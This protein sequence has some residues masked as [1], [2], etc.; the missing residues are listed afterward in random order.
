MSVTWN[1]P[2][3]YDQVMAA[4]DRELA[5]IGGFL[6]D[7]MQMY[8]PV[9]S[10]NLKAGIHEV[11]DTN[12]HAV[13]V[14]IPAPYSVYQ[15]LGT[16]Y[17]SPHP[18]IRPAILD[19]V[20]VWDLKDVTIIL[21]PPPQKSEPLRATTSGFKLPRHQ[22]LTAQQVMHVRTN[23]RPVSKSFAGKFKRRGVKFKIIGPK[24]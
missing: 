18:F 3:V 14:Y 1:G 4:V 12:I 2:A 16:R 5:Q 24:R 19:A 9:E 20:A 22:Q 21:H 6:V 8:A 10:G 13:T 7:H 15:E 11:V 23:L 17:I